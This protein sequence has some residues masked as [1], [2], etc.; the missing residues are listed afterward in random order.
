A[1]L[2][3]GG[4]VGG[5]VLLWKLTKGLLGR[6]VDEGRGSS[7]AAGS[8]AGLALLAESPSNRTT[9]AQQM[10]VRALQTVY[11][12]G[13]A[14]GMWDLHLTDAVV[15]I[16]CSASI[17]YAYALRPETLDQGFYRFIRDTGPVPEPVLEAVRRNVRGLP[18]ET[19]SPTSYISTLHPPPSI[20]ASVQSLDPLPAMLPCSVLHAR[21]PG[22]VTQNL[23]R[24]FGKVVRVILPVYFSVFAIPAVLLK[25]TKVMQRPA[26][27]A[28]TILFNT[29]RSATFLAT[30]CSSY[31]L[32]ICGVRQLHDLGIVQRDHEL[33]YW[34]AGVL[35]SMS[36]F[37]EEK[38]RR[39]ELAMY[40]VP[41]AA[42]SIFEILLQRKL[43]VRV[44]HFEVAMFSVAMGVLMAFYDHEPQT[45]TRFVSRI[46]RQ[47]DL[48]IDGSNVPPSPL[49]A[50]GHSKATADLFHEDVFVPLKDSHTTSDDGNDHASEPALPR[51]HSRSPSLGELARDEEMDGLVAATE[52]K[53]R[54]GV[55]VRTDY[56]QGQAA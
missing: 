14:R 46:L 44:P 38:S 24:V 22:C 54:E 21:H 30:F 39:C 32:V 11:L 28:Q 23:P 13:K 6:W 33:F 5:Y 10:A 36:I 25:F 34:L 3:T 29:A 20:L 4:F 18:V 45:M 7:F 35:C 26:H 16:V 31:Q 43:I 15:F 1:A 47:I 9:F 2:R 37:I 17:M 50:N 19:P 48:F 51:H 52:E 53:R 12:G 49:L 8:I 56:R 40:T 41:R 42:D 55:L 27:Y